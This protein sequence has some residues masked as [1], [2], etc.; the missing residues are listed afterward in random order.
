[1]RELWPRG[2]SAAI[3]QR[4]ERPGFC[5]PAAMR[6]FMFALG[7]AAAAASFGCTNGN[8]GNSGVT[9]PTPTVVTETFTGSIGQNGTMIHSFTITNSGYS[10]LAGYTSIGPAT[11]TSLGLGIGAWDASSQTC[12]LNQTQND[13]AKIGSTA[14]SATAPSGPFCMR[15]YDGGNITDPTVTVTYT[16]VVEHY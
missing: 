2:D 1:V 4:I 8:S 15:V 11:V 12:G 16:L 9:G 13:A 6:Q 14:I 5:W 7:M 10:L 3:A